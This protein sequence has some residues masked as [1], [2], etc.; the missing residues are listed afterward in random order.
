[1]SQLLSRLKSLRVLSL[2]ACLSALMLTT[3]CREDETVIL[4]TAEGTGSPAR[5]GIIKGMYLLCEGNMGSNK[6]TVDFL[7][8]APTGC[9]EMIYHRNIYSERSPHVMKELGDVGNDLKVYG[10]KLWMVI[11]CSNKVEVATAASCTRVGQIDIPNCR[12]LAFDG[13]Y[14]YVSAY[15]TPVG[16]RPDAGVGAVYKVDT[17][18]L[19][20]VGCLPVGYQPEEMAV[21]GGKLYVTHSGGYLA[22]HYDNRLAVIDLAS[23]TLDSYLEIAPN[24]HHCRA[25][26][27][28]Q[29]W[30]TSQGNNNGSAG[31][32]HLLSPDAQ[33]R[34]QV[35]GQLPLQVADCC[36]VGDSLY[37]LTRSGNAGSG[38][39]AGLSVVDVAR[40]SVVE[41]P[42]SASTAAWPSL[43]VETPYGIM[44]DPV[45][46]DLYLM[47]A[48]NYVS[49]GELL[50]FTADGTP[51]WRVRTGDIPA[52]AAFI[53]EKFTGDD[54]GS[55]PPVTGDEGYIAGVD[56][57]VPAPGQFVNTM[58]VYT[59]GDGASEMCRKC[60]EALAGRQSGTVTL[61]GYGGYITFHFARPVRN[62][63]GQ[64]DFMIWG[65][66]L[67]TSSEPGVVL[68]SQ[69]TN[70]NG[71]PDDEWYEL[72]GSADTDSTG[73][74][75]Y[76]YRI[77]YTRPDALSDIPWTDNR[78]G[79]GH[80]FRNSFHTQDYYP[81]WL[82]ATLS[83]AGTLLPANTHNRGTEGMENWVSEPYR[84]GYADNLPNSD[85]AG[86][87]FRIDHAVDARRRPVRLTHIDFVRVCSATNQQC[88]WTG[89][90]STE[91]TG[92]RML[93]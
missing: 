83:F 67:P 68:V 89:E 73:K 27:Y 84:Y 22:P 37:C 92:A 31:A 60:A 46:K 33:G 42:L 90:A 56:E 15:V 54:S 51:D 34:M 8:Y 82:P 7:D 3:A 38:G 39:S 1:M 18:T 62:I 48:K 76:D 61:G 5:P 43:S 72:K 52:H 86:C 81:Q 2:L 10:S 47:D 25:D 30:V 75:I 6:A 49:G 9:A 58:P 91:I 13:G 14:A 65:N 87:S 29:L 53:C 50:H 4:S 32:L 74:V 64:A 80:I 26:R 12:Y 24:L 21:C 57:Y 78:G 40:H 44:V 35:A 63:P 36:L 45:G 17:L 77:T 71:L 66:A 20:I 79:S 85:E 11:N 93:H 70:A 88:G 55:V 28:G 19:Q 41:N 59:P 23:F 16:V 69:D